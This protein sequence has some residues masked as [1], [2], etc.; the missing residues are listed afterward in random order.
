MCEKQS[1]L[2]RS[3]GSF[4]LDVLGRHVLRRRSVR[5][6]RVHAS[7]RRWHAAA[8]RHRVDSRRR[9]AWR[10][11]TAAAGRRQLLLLLLRVLHLHLLLLL[12]LHLHLLLMELLLLLLLLLRVHLHHLLLCKLLLLRVAGLSAVD[13]AGGHHYRRAVRVSGTNDDDVAAAALA[14]AHAAGHAEAAGDGDANG[15]HDE[16]DDA[17]DDG[18]DDAGREGGHAVAD[19]SR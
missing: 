16:Q 7:W 18:G 12:H 17:D 15:H 4:L 8:V 2:F 6:H 19:A 3:G 10:K 9:V 1:L 5:V 14:A 11:A 13:L